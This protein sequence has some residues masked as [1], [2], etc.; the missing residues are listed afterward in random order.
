M[1]LYSHKSGPTIELFQGNK[2]MLINFSQGTSSDG[3]AKI[4]IFKL[5]KSCKETWL[6]FVCAWPFGTILNTFKEI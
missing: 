3:V 1:E 5:A 6:S 2:H 4:L